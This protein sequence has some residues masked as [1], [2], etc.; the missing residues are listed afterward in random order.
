M[1]GGAVMRGKHVAHWSIARIVHG[2]ALREGVRAQNGGTIK[3]RLWVRTPI[4]AR[5][6][7]APL[8]SLSRRET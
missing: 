5:A 2:S 8:N 1:R 6:T 3:L 7:A 4:E